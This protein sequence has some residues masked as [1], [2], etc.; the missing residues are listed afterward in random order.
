[1]LPETS[2]FFFGDDSSEHY[3]EEDLTFIKNART[4]LANGEEVFYDSW[5]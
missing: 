3:R 5:W 4:S 2:G 1:M